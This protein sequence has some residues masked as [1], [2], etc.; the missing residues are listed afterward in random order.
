M[1]FLRNKRL[2]SIIVLIFLGATYSSLFLLNFNRNLELAESTKVRDVQYRAWKFLTTETNFF[3]RVQNRD[4]MLSMSQDDSFEYNAGTFYVNTGIRLAYFFNTRTL[5]PN[6][7]E[8]PKDS[9][10]ELPDLRKTIKSTL[11]NLNRVT[12]INE[13]QIKRDWVLSNMQEGALD[14]SVFW[15]TDLILLTPSTLFGYLG[16]FNEQTAVSI[17]RESIRAVLLTLSERTFTPSLFGVCMVKTSET[18]DLNKDRFRVSTWKLPNKGFSPNNNVTEL[19]I[20][21]DY[22]DL[23][24]GTCA[25]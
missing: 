20:S 22:R 25:K 15:A 6:F 8:C 21:V 24:V 10:C 13:K 2:I 4:V 12:K 16:V 7:N 14:K 1:E 5:F 3:E 18:Y 9:L 17:D 11:P 23:R 19:P